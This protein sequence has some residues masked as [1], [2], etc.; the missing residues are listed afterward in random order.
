MYLTLWFSVFYPCSVPCKPNAV[1]SYSLSEVKN[2]KGICLVHMNARSLLKHFDKIEYSLLD[3]RFE[4]VIATESWLHD[5]VG[6]NLITTKLYNHHRLDRRTLSV[7]GHVKPGGG[8]C[9]YTRKD[10]VVTEV[11][12]LSLSN[13]DIELLTLVLQIRNHKRIK[14]IA[15]YRPPSGNCDTAINCIRETLNSVNRDLSG[16]VVIMGDL[17]INLADNNNSQSK[18]LVS[19]A[20]SMFLN[21]LIK[22]PTRVTSTSESLIDHILTDIPH[23]NLSGTINLNLTDHFP[24]FV[25]KKKIRCKKSFTEVTGRKY[26]SAD[27]TDFETDIRAIDTDTLFRS[28]NP[29]K[30]WGALFEQIMTIVDRHFPI[31]S[32]KIPNSRP[33]YLDETLVRLMHQRDIAFRHARRD[34]TPEAWSLARNFRSRVNRDVRVARK[35]SSSANWK[36]LTV[37]ARSFG[38]SLMTP[39][40]KPI[41][42]RSKK[43]WM[44]QLVKS[45]PV[46]LLQK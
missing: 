36:W 41:Q 5:N 44:R 6:D 23:V 1:M 17:N 9:I 20:E 32:F 2:V 45:V 27:L 7:N 3:G 38:M 18:K 21:Q 33:F 4:A 14:L 29:N 13:A 28:G 35:T 42:R 37:I 40:L 15:A 31:R 39:F 46:K 25:I 22:D 26:K 11:S 30:I 8:I 10:V 16:D 43:S 24:I 34:S 19:F 12:A